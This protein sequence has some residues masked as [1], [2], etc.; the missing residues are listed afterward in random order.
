M[1]TKIRSELT[2]IKKTTEIT[3]EQVLCWVKIVEAQ[4]VHKAITDAK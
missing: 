3:G 4:G 1:M 2:T